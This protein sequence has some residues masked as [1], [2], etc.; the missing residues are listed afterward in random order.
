MWLRDLTDPD[1]MLTGA[2]TELELHDYTMILMGGKQSR[3]V[4]Q[5]LLPVLTQVLSHII[6]TKRGHQQKKT[7]FHLSAQRNYDK[8]NRTA[9]QFQLASFCARFTRLFACDDVIIRFVSALWN[10]AHH[11]HHHPIVLCRP[12]SRLVG[13]DLMLNF[14]ASRL[15]ECVCD[16]RVRLCDSDLHS[17][18][19]RTLISA[20]RE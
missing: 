13:R 17:F 5:A 3:P 2:V 19:L 16:V 10:R 1:A 11:R 9:A 14:A 8:P 7:Y 18:L 6:R 12:R 4:D 20:A 15:M